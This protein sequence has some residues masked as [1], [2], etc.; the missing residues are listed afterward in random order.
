MKIADLFKVE[1]YGVVI[2]GGAS[3]LGLGFAEALAEN[4]ARVTLLDI[5]AAR[6]ASEVR[7]LKELGYDVRGEVADVTDHPALD[8]AFDNAAKEYGKIDV[9]FANAGID[10]GPGYLNA[11]V[12]DKRERVDAGAIEHYAD[13]R[14]ER[15]ININLNGV[16]ATCR[17]AARHMRPRRSGRIIVTTSLAGLTQEAVIGRRL[18]GGQGRRGAFHAQPGAG[19][20][21]LWHLRQ[22]HRAG[23]LRHQYRR[24]ARAQSRDAEDGFRA[25]ADAPRRL[26]EGH[27]RAGAVSG[28]AG[29]RIHHRAA[30]RHRRR[31]GPRRGGLIRR[32]IS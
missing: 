5:D 25:G 32:K 22:R 21:G 6:I 31:L 7:R 15:T 19:A 2:T 4:G 17:A 27:G 18:Y 24:R 16:F 14:W 1:G 11:W 12:G 30:D 26:A 23:L 10:S 28:V 20:G 8:R 3:G 29:L 9:V 13:E